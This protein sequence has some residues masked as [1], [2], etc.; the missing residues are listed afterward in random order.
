M[1]TRFVVIIIIIII[2]IERSDSFKDFSSEENLLVY[3][4]N[5]RVLLPREYRPDGFP[6]KSDVLNTCV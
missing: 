3:S 6:W 4:R 1:L 5:N 2:I